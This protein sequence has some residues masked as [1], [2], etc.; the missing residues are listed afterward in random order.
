MMKSFLDRDFLCKER[1]HALGPC[2]WLDLVHSRKMTG[3]A[4]CKD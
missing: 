4:R 3:V 1:E 2:H